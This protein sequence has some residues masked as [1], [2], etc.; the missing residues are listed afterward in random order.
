MGDE[1]AAGAARRMFDVQ[2]LVIE[3]VL[4]SA[5]RYIGAIHAAIEQDVVGAGVVATELASPGAIAP[6]DVGT[7]EFS[8]EVLSV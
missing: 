4:D 5:L 8:F 3:D 2:H 7:S 1:R 6:A